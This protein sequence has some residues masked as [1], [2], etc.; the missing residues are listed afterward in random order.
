MSRH[1]LA[2]GFILVGKS[3]CGWICDRSCFSNHNVLL[4]IADQTRNSIKNIRLSFRL[5]LA[6]L[7][8]PSKGVPEHMGYHGY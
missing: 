1:A 2:Y 4:Y 3:A 8:L 6:S 7:P 5:L